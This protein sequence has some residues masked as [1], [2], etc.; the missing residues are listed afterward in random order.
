MTPSKMAANKTSWDLI[1]RLPRLKIGYASRGSR[2]LPP[3][4]PPLVL[5]LTGNNAHLVAP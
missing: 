1:M 2:G 5:V 3:A 4:P